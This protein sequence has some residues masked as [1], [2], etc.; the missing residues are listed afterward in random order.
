[1]LLETFLPVLSYLTAYLP[2]WLRDISC[3]L[4]VRRAVENMH[5]WRYTLHDAG[6]GSHPNMNTCMY[7]AALISN[8]SGIHTHRPVRALS[9]EGLPA[10][11]STDSA[12]TA[13]V[14]VFVIMLPA[15]FRHASVGTYPRLFCHKTG[16]SSALALH[17]QIL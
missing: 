14:V 11:R 9:K 1:M 13:P 3:L 6:A 7:V 12:N 16:I 17:K 15:K 10:Y 5:P 2:Q 8:A 4:H